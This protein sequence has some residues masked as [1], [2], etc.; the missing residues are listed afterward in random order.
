L[1]INKTKQQGAASIKILGTG[2]FFSAPEL[3]NSSA[4]VTSQGKRLLIDC[5][6]RARD[7]LENLDMTPNDIDAIFITHVHGDH[8]QGL[9]RFGYEMRFIYRRKQKLIFHKSIYHQ[10]W[11]E[12]LK[13]SMKSVGEGKASLE[14][15]FDVIALENMSFE[16]YGLHFDLNWM[17]HTPDHPTCSLL[18]NSDVFWSSDTNT[19]PELLANLQFRV[20]FHDCNIGPPN[21]VHAHIDEIVRD[22]PQ[23]IRERLWAIHGEHEREESKINGVMKGVA[24]V[25]DVFPILPLKTDR[26]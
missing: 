10:L 26:E 20:G 2:D 13:G 21:R 4:I 6:F 15:Y 3:Y 11:D 12:T 25:G 17:R 14:D 22:Y 5:G 8:V 18:I 16:L 19:M 1:S 7:A 23:E 24:R 9:E